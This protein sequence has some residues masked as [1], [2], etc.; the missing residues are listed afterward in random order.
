MSTIKIQW[1]DELKGIGEGKSSD[2]KTVFL[3]SKF[4]VSNN[5]FLTLKKHELVNCEIQ[6]NKNDFYATKIKRR[7]ES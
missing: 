7:N 5:S 6:K 3:N 4:I 1:F 2:G